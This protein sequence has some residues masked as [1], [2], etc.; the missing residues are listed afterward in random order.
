MVTIPAAN[1]A[2]ASRY[3]RLSLP[4]DGHALPYGPSVWLLRVFGSAEGASGPAAT[5]TGAG[6]GAGAG[7]GTQVTCMTTK[8]E[9]TMDVHPEWSPLGA[10]NFLKLVNGGYFTMVPFFRVVK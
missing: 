10:E 5:A 6:A 3:V 1:Q 8:G 7:A 4:A 2:Q 9:L